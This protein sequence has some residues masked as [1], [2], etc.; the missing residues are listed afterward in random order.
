MIRRYGS[1]LRALLMT[2]DAVLA[3]LTAVAVYQMRFLVFP[4]D[5]DPTVFNPPAAAL[6]V[7]AG[8]WVLIL[9]LRGQ[10]R[11]RAH[12]TVRS[13]VVGVLQAV[14]WLAAACFV[15]L[16]FLKLDTA[17]RLFLLLLFPVQAA[18][19][20]I[21]RILIRVMFTELRRRGRNGRNVLIV[22][23]GKPAVDFARLITG[24]G[25]LGLQVAGFVGVKPPTRPADWPYLG[26]V[27]ALEAILQ[28]HVI[29]EVAICLPSSQLADAAG[30]VRMAQDQGK[31]V[32]IPL[33]IPLVGHG[34]S[35]FEDL[36]GTA[37]LS[38]T[39]GPEQLAA[40]AVKRLIDI[41]GALLGLLILGP[42]ILAAAA[43]I[44]IKDG[45]P[46]LFV[47]TRVGVHGRPFR[48]YK[49][50]TMVRDAEARYPE[51]AARSETQGAAFKMTNDPRIT[52][53][54]RVIRRTSIDELPQLWNV[55]LGQMSLVG[56]R[57]APPREVQA[58][59]VWHRRRLSM[60]PGIT[61]LWQITSRLD[62][63]FDAR[64]ALDLDY[65]DRWSLWLDVRIVAMTLP[66]LLRSPGH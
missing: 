36:D 35:Q 49:L 14:L 3:A 52:S 12:W 46:V 17:S 25:Y 16:V 5:S 55:L 29:D 24:R 64:A 42:V 53:W 45:R 34:H 32:R 60:K 43:Y 15:V 66:A 47:Q 30:I 9:Y 20:I 19:T 22:G 27:D 1:M 50:R 37:V 63:H 41:V 57:P 61:G 65:I 54:G 38:L 23:T 7:Y 28:D 33:D 44:L 21:T 6:A 4:G 31:I 48:L 39:S 8:L 56:P 26:D 58:Y 18:V 10:Y 40:L 11:L 59:D 13:E 51:V 62:D 2:A